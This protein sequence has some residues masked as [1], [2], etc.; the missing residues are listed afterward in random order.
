MAEL[1]AAQHLH[2]EENEISAKRQVEMSLQAF[3]RL[4]PRVRG[5]NNLAYLLSVGAFVCL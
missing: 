2:K 5:E 3:Y 4:L 1:Q